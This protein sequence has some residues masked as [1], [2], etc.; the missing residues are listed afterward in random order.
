[1]S[2]VHWK[3][4]LTARFLLNAK[5]LLAHAPKHNE[6]IAPDD[7]NCYLDK[8]FTDGISRSLRDVEN[9]PEEQRYQ[10][11]AMQSMVFARIAGI[12]AG[13]VAL[14]EDPMRRT[15]EALMHGYAEGESMEPADHHHHGHGGH[16]HSGH[17]NGGQDHHH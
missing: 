1:M 5:D 3:M 4:K 6:P 10:R 13:H 14:P 12:L 16:D 2:Q 15:L 17:G 7:I 8:L 11:L 9:A